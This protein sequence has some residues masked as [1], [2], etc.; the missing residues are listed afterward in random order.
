VYGVFTDGIN[1]A[2]Y[3]ERDEKTRWE[4]RRS[5]GKKEQDVVSVVN[6]LAMPSSISSGQRRIS[7]SQFESA[8]RYDGMWE[9]STFFQ[10]KE[11]SVIAVI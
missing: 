1:L 2:C 3:G 6:S 5:G 7:G 4:D 11:G 9:R 8:E 10:G